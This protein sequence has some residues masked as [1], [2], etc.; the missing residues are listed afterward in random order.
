MLK[1]AKKSLEFWCRS[2]DFSQIRKILFGID[3]TLINKF[4]L[5]SLLMKALPFLLLSPI[6]DSPTFAR[7]VHR[8]S[9]ALKRQ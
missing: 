1:I 4:G 8:L 2:G 7:A 5:A 9:I 6:L 3:F